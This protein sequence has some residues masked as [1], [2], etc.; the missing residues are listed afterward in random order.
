MSDDN[1]RMAASITPLS[2]I[3]VGQGFDQPQGYKGKGTKGKGQGQDFNTPE[4]PLPL[5]RVRGFCKGCS[6]VTFYLKRNF[7]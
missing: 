5:T 1:E 2:V 7:I 4:K 6:R 3:S